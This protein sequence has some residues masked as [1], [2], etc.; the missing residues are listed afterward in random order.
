MISKTSSDELVQDNKTGL[1]WVCRDNGK[2]VGCLFHDGRELNLFKS[3]GINFLVYKVDS[4]VLSDGFSKVEYWRN[5][6]YE[7]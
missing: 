3:L 1:M 7:F 5:A 2:S 4:K 6:E